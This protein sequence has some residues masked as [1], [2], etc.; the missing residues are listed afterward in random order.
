[1]TR[2]LLIVPVTLGLILIGW[3][4]M[5]LDDLSGGWFLRI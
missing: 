4:I 5:M 3:W 2:E 1:M